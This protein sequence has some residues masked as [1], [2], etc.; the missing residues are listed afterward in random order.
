[1]NEREF[2][3]IIIIIKILKEL[4]INIIIDV[5]R[6]SMLKHLICIQKYNLKM[7]LKRKGMFTMLFTILWGVLFLGIETVMNHLVIYL[8]FI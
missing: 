5:N 4:K 6:C 7:L 3:I 8:F 1:M 2:K